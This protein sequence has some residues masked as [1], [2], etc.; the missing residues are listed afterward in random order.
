MCKGWLP[1]YPSK[2]DKMTD[3]TTKQIAGNNAANETWCGVR[4]VPKEPAKVAEA[5]PQKDAKP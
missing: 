2:L 5:T 3:G 1:I 4:P